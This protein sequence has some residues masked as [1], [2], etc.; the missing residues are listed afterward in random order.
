MSSSLEYCQHQET[1]LVKL[2]LPF[3][4]FLVIFQLVKVFIQYLVAYSISA[5]RDDDSPGARAEYFCT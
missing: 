2:A 4:V 1:Y 5:K 3:Y